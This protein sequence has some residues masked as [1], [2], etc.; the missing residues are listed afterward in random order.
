MSSSS[1]MVPSASLALSALLAPTR[2]G[3][4]RTHH[5][6]ASSSVA[7]FAPAC[8]GWYTP[9]GA[10]LAR[11]PRLVSVASP[12]VPSSATPNSTTSPRLARAYEVAGVATAGVWAACAMGALATYK[13]WRVTHNAIGV[14][15]ALAAVPLISGAASSLAA[16]ARGRPPWRPEDVR[17]LSFGFAAA[18]VW[19]VVAVLLAPRL[20]AAMVR[21]SDPVTYPPL[22]RAVAVSVHFVVSVLC[23]FSMWKPPIADSGVVDASDSD[24]I[25]S[26]SQERGVITKSA[27]VV[28]SVFFAVFALLAFTPFPLA[29]VPSLLGKRLARAHGAWLLL[30]AVEL[31]VLSRHTGRPLASVAP[32]RRGVRGAVVIH[33]GVCA[34]R[35]ALESSALYPAAMA[36]LPAVVAS[37][38]VY[39]CLLLVSSR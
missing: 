26:S 12:A 2:D 39:V 7:R 36:C 24:V 25:R 13:P 28:L 22:L 1:R 19:S 37:Y 14:L 31:A 5:T 18:S 11:P 38:L 27:Y 23:C 35:V 33:L 3:P 4:P 15:Q 16:A 20:T 6:A 10:A 9:R 32:L 34:V 29:T 8:A 30:A 17:Q 21:T